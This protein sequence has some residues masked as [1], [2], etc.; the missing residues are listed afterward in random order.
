[1]AKWK[2]T[3]IQYDIAFGDPEKNYEAIE[4]RIERAMED[5]PNILV[6]PELWTTG[7]DLT[8]L[9]EIAEDQAS[10][11]KSFLSEMARKHGVHLVGGSTA[12]STPQGVFNTMLVYD[13]EGRLCSEYDKAHLFQLMDE[14]LHLNTGTEKGLFELDHVRSAGVVCYDIRFPEWI[15]AH[16]SDGAEVL[17]VV[18]EWPIERLDHWRAL[19]MARAIENQCWVVACNRIG[20]DPDHDFA[21]HSTIIDPWGEV[22]AEANETDEF[23]TAEIDTL[24]VQETRGHIPVFSDRRPELYR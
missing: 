8:R 16:M 19:L 18:A 22:I 15:R 9:G 24:A 2:I 11:T 10:R 3:C 17:F 23:L 4:A 13:R 12:K 1:M 6:L 14:H 20:S 7:Y 21:G 5:K